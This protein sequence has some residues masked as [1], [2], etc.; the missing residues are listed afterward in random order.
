MAKKWVCMNNMPYI[1]RDVSWLS[2]NY[3]VLQEAKDPSVPLLE[4]V[5]FLAIYSSNLDEFFRIRIANHRNLLRV[6]KKTMRKLD[7]APAIT[8]NNIL[9]IVKKQQEEFSYIFENQI[10]PLLQENKIF[11]LRGYELNPEQRDFI[12]TFFENHLLPFVQPVLLVKNK[13][14]PFLNNAALYLVLHLRELELANAPSEFAIIKIPSDHLP[15]FIHLPSSRPERYDLIILDDVVRH[16]V[17]WLFPG[18][19]IIDSYSIKLTRDAELYIDDE[20]SGDLIQKIRRSLTKRNIG[21]ASRLVYDREIPDKVLHFLM[22]VFELAEEDL[23]PEGRYHNN[24]DFFTFPNFDKIH[25]KE[26]PLP[27]LPHPLEKAP[28]YFAAILQSDHMVHMPY[29][30]YESVILFFEKAA[31]DPHVTHI[32]IIQY[33]VAAVSRIMSALIRAVK[34]GKH[35][36]AF[37][38]VKARFDEQANIEWGE[39]LE[40]AGV[41]VHYSF[42]G[43]KVHA[44]VAL[45]RRV[46]TRGAMIYTY[47]STGNFHEG[48]ARIYSDFGLFTADRKL[49]REAARLFSY[50]ETVKRPRTP[51]RHILVGQF[52]FREKLEDYIRFE[53]E[54]AKAGK[55]SYILLKLNSLQDTQM[56]ALLYEASQ[57]GV[58]IK[59]IIRGICSLVPGVRGYS[60][61]I[62]CISIVD[63]FLEHARVYVFHHGGKEL[64]YLGSA[65]WMTRNLSHRIETAIPVYNPTIKKTIHDLLQIQ[66]NDNVKAR[67]VKHKLNNQYKRDGSDLAIRSQTETYY[68][69]KRLQDEL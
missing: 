65:D 25:L 37:I 26:I 45:V 5:K 4:R 44:K 50:L 48:T 31:E 21:P 36:S 33:R 53:I 62:E 34:A 11:L 68:Y 51:F 46:E 23:M 35:V 18:Y 7:Y 66:L 59:L 63:R 67:L 10:V 17:Q 47:F 56:I 28:D 14:R 8:L 39:K 55:P 64:M 49:T 12:D 24:S 60:E 19:E 42:P 29:Q 57:A 58:K 22:Q 1:D 38:E 13:I 3:R 40:K 43:L 61:N 2:F 9:K 15:R 54:Q 27:P 69:F 32:K 52:G 30:S 20:F 41:N 6:G 16:S